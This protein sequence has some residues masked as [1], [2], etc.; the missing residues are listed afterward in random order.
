M[1]LGEFLSSDVTQHVHVGRNQM[2]AAILSLT[3][4]ELVGI[5]E[6]THE[7]EIVED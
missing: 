7:G 1:G 2:M 4:E 3:F 5:E 6:G